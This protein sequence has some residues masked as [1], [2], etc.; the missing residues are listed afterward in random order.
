[1]QKFPWVLDEIGAVGDKRFAIVI[2]EAHSARAA[3]LRPP[4]AKAL[5]EGAGAADDDEE[6]DA[7]DVVNAALEAPHGSAQDADE[8]QLL[9]LH[10]HA[11]EQ[12]AGDVRSRC[13]PMLK[14]K[15]KHAPS[16]TTA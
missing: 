8:R 2:D 15:V 16:T 10:G 11:E 14:G 12:D 9:R 13:R 3:R 7:E 5:G 4:W 1:M 6:R